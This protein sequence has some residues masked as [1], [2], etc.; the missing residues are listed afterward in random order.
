MFVPGRNPTIE[1]LRSEFKVKQI[2]L[3]ENI[4]QDEKISEIL[5]LCAQKHVDI[6]SVGRKQLQRHA[7]TEPHQGV[8]A[9]VD[10]YLQ[11]LNRD[12][13]QSKPGFYL[14]IREAQYEQNVGAIIRTAECAGIAG[15]ILPPKM[16]VT[17]TVARISMGALFHVPTYYGS[18]FPTIKIFHDL[19]AEVMAMEINGESN[20]YETAMPNDVLMI[21]GGEDRSISPEIA[22]QCDT[23]VKIPQ[24]GQVNS[25]NMSVAAALCM[26]EY[27]RQVK[28]K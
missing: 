6:K 7:G 9:D 19:S 4:N 24:F 13:L 28:L 14:Y 20:I 22:K 16:E 8:V 15:V 12:V 2:L 26:Y 5:R 25:L 21:V 27:V 10:F 11:N 3:E 17:G 23:I 18:L 1:A